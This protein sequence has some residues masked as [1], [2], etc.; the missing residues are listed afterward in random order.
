MVA[1]LDADKEGFLRSYRSL[2]QTIGRAA[3][4]AEG[5]VVLYADKMTDSIKLALDETNRRRKKQ[6]EY[7]LKHGI[8]PKTIRKAIS[9]TLMTMTET[10]EEKERKSN[11]PTL[12]ELKNIDKEIKRL[13]KQMKDYA[14]DLEF[15]KAMQ[16]RDDIKRLE[17][18][19]LALE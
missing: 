3:R 14:A 10:D 1:I 2:I 8:T 12:G 16:C 15:E 4:N 19:R 7:N 13:T 5:K 11:S 17:T 18:A 6:F 9:N